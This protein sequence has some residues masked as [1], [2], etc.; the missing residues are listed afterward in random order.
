MTNVEIE[1]MLEREICKDAMSEINDVLSNYERR[2]E[3]P[4]GVLNE[5]DAIVTETVYGGANGSRA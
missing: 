4:H 2:A 1:R 3:D 5:I